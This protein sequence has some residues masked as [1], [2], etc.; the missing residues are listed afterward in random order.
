MHAPHDNP[1]APLLHWGSAARHIID[2]EELMSC[3]FMNFPKIIGLCRTAEI[4]EEAYRG[5]YHELTAVIKS[6]HE[7]KL[8][9]KEAWPKS[10]NSLESKYRPMPER[11]NFYKFAKRLEGEL[12]PIVRDYLR[13]ID[14]TEV[15]TEILTEKWV[16]LDSARLGEK[17]HE[18]STALKEVLILID[19]SNEPD[20][21]DI[22]IKIDR[23][24]L[25]NLLETVLHV[26]RAPKVEIGLLKKTR[27]EA[28]AIAANSARK[29][30]QIAIGGLMSKI[31]KS[32]G[33]L[34]SSL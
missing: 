24:Q 10:D 4:S 32:L 20:E 16:D 34:I 21:L 2:D 8:L 31:G 15:R 14:E 19:R 13:T 28:Q 11:Q 18:I 25:I 9:S 23:E 5:E 12:R 3:V 1:T 6:L 33:E 30:A 7:A 27:T 29:Q 22:L 26:L 17:I